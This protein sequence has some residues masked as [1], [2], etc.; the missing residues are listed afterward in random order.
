MNA[1]INAQYNIYCQGAM[2]HLRKNKAGTG[3]ERDI[4]R[5]G[6]G[7]GGYYFKKGPPKA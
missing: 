2:S 5:S 7:V 4:R 1:E 6:G 3:R